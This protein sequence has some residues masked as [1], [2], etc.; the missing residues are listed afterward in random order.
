MLAALTIEQIG[1]FRRLAEMR[2]RDQ[3]AMQDYLGHGP[4]VMAAVLSE[5]GA[6]DCP[7]SFCLQDDV[8]A[9]DE[10]ARRELTA[11][12]LL[13]RGERTTFP[14]ALAQAR[15]MQDADRVR[16][17]IPKPL[18][19]YLPIALDRLGIIPPAS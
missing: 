4:R 1:E 16:Y 14:T 9:L 10:P 12:V 5:A 17:L 2:A 6:F 3:R 18:H 7:E 8:A 13:A 11:L 19:L 15:A